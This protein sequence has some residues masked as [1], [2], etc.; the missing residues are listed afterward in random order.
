VTT[1]SVVEFEARSY[2][3]DPYGHLNN[4]V[5]INWL[6]QGRLVYLRDRGLT[7]DSVPK[8]FGV[9][10]MVVQQGIAYK[11]Q[12]CLGDHLHCRSRILRFGNSS[13]T[14]E[15]VIEYPDGRQAAFAT[16]TMVCVGE[17]GKAAPM[18]PEL[19][20]RLET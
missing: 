14:F 6:E 9:K 8:L 19:R 17:D 11:A 18:P 13:F 1:P 2:E 20:R 12:V 15:Q 4:A 5:Y 16:V 3:L 10:V 7:Y